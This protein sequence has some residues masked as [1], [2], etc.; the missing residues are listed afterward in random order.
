MRAEL[1]WARRQLRILCK[2]AEVKVPGSAR[3]GCI[4]SLGWKRGGSG[5]RLPS[6]VPFGGG[7]AALTQPHAHSRRMLA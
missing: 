1:T 2:Y 5:F 6:P 3:A 4:G 7:L